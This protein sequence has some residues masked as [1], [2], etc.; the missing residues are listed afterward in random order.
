[1]TPGGGLAIVKH[2]SDPFD[3][4]S[5]SMQ[6]KQT[7]QIPKELQCPICK[8][9]LKDAVT[10]ACCGVNFCDHCILRAIY[11]DPNSCCPNCKKVKCSSKDLT[12]NQKI[13]SIIES[14]NQSINTETSY[15]KPNYEKDTSSHRGP[16]SRGPSE[17]KER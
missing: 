9:I 14:K 16:S 15:N 17:D 13:R 7:N 1:M 11:D 3:K 6:R 2:N 10:T 8:N 5:Q 12:P 4:L